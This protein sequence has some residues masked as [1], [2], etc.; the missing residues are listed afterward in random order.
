[1]ARILS[2]FAIAPNGNGDYLITL[3]DEQGDTVEFEAS[4]EQLDLV[5]EALQE[6]LDSDEEDAL[7]VDDETADDD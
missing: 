1:M 6:Q 3:D 7:E 2:H 4:Y 5:A